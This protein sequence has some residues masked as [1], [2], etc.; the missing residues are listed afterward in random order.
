[1]AS[2][3]KVL[4]VCTG[5]TCRSPMAEGLFKKA[6]SDTGANN[7]EV[8]GSCGVATGDGYPISPESAQVL[9]SHDASLKE[10]SSTVANEKLI[11]DADYVFAMTQGHLD[12]LFSFFPEHAEKLFLMTDFVDLGNGVGEDISDPIGLGQ[13]AYEATA[14]MMIDS[15]PSVIAFVQDDLNSEAELEE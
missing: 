8:L 7:I 9:A 14:K 3:A 2:P 10:F 13:P 12:A 6:L 1:M 4:F 5:N 11:S 15:I